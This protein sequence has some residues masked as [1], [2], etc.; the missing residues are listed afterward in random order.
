MRDQMNMGKLISNTYVSIEE[1]F[2]DGYQL[3][4]IMTNVKFCAEALL[5]RQRKQN[6]ST[7]QYCIQRKVSRRIKAHVVMKSLDDVLQYQLL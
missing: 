6:G 5:V 7:Q 2:R 1:L 3:W 4:D